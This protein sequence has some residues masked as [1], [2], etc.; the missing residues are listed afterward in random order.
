MGK[1]E[2]EEDF[3]LYTVDDDIKVYI[4]KKILEALDSGERVLKFVIP[5]YGWHYLTL[6]EVP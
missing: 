6:I 3:V 2:N 5:E 4:D 1:P